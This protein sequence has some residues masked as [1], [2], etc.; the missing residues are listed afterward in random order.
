MFVHN[1]MDLR[2]KLKEIS[3]HIS[4]WCPWHL[5]DQFGYD[6]VWM[7]NIEYLFSF[8][9]IICFSTDQSKKYFTSETIFSQVEQISANFQ[10][11]FN[12]WI[13]NLE[14]QISWWT[15]E[16]INYS[17]VSI[18]RTG[19]LTILKFFGTLNFFFMY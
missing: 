16:D 14:N 8:L 1:R 15:A 2:L 19:S 9:I 4:F 5:K 13:S 6:E 10:Y 18:K 11:I 7:S 3:L 12:V 17:V